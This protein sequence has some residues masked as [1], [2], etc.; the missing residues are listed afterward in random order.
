MF[1]QAKTMNQHLLQ[2]HRQCVDDV[3]QCL[4]KAMVFAILLWI[5]C[6]FA[7]ALFEHK[8]RMIKVDSC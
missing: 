1:K 2:L 3:L 6:V 5:C 4:S 8:W 7:F